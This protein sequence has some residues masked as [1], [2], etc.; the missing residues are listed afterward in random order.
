MQRIYKSLGEIEKEFG[1]QVAEACKRTI[2]D[3]INN[4]T[5]RNWER[6]INASG[7]SIGDGFDLILSVKKAVGFKS[8]DLAGAEAFV[9][10]PLKQYRIS[11]AHRLADGDVEEREFTCTA[12]SVQG[13]CWLSRGKSAEIWDNHTDISE[14]KKSWC[15]AGGEVLQ[16]W[17]TFR[18]DAKIIKAGY[19]PT[20]A[21]PVCG[22]PVKT[23]R[24][25]AGDVSYWMIPRHKEARN[26]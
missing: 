5:G 8:G 1:P 7:V 26:D 14:Y 17:S 11:Y 20:I 2:L 13:A 9:G 21:C 25:L 12:F 16:P 23:R 24:A 3:R 15:S 22:K 18:R 4:P 19:Y 6:F 10:R